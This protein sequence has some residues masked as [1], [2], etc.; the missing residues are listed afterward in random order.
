[1]NSAARPSPTA[2]IPT[3][4]P[5]ATTIPTGGKVIGATGEFGFRAV[6][7]PVHVHD[8]HATILK[9]LGLDH[10]KL[11]FLFKGRDQRLTDVGG[12]HE[13]AARLRS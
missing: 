13:F 7:D 12:D 6:E 2:A 3:S 11:T 10:T 9:L 8:L 4:V 5:A 1:M